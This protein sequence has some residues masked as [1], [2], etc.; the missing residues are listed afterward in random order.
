MN[1]RDNPQRFLKQDVTQLF[2]SCMKPG[3]LF[4]LLF[5]FRSRKK[6]ALWYHMMQNRK[7]MIEDS[8]QRQEKVCLLSKVKGLSTVSSPALAGGRDGFE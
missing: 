3:T 7:M 1:T 6:F 5:F 4:T 2:C 8:E